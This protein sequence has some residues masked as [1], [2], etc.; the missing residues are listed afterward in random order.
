[1]R[2]AI[3]F[4]DDGRPDYLA[5][6][7]ESVER[8][9]GLS[10]SDPLILINDAGNPEYSETLLKLYFRFERIVNHDERRG[11]AGAVRS[12]WETALEQDVDYVWHME[13]DFILTQNLFLSDMYSVLKE[14]PQLAQLVLKRQPW[15]PEEIQAGGQIE[16]APELYVDCKG[17]VSHKRLFSFNPCL[18]PRHVVEL[19]LAGP[20][21]GLERGVTDTLLDAGY[22][23]GY[24]GDRFD[25]PRCE[26]IGI[27]RSPGYHW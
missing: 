26:H 11:L 8:H 17:F 19:A 23:F 10:L 4:I 1:M 6:S 18:I 2:T 20:G 15:S 13:G 16:T 25:P 3:V 5:Q 22:S 21:D 24:L 14:N 7:V 27:N 12:A 9:V